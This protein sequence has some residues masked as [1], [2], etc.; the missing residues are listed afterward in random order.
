MVI[1][2]MIYVNAV[3]ALFAGLA[4]FIEQPLADLCCARRL[5]WG[6]AAVLSLAV[7]AVTIATAP[8]GTSL[9]ILDV[10]LLASWAIASIALVASV[11]Y[12]WM[13]FERSVSRF[14]VVQ[15]GEQTVRVSD[16]G[17]A[18]FGL[19]QAAILLPQWLLAG[20]SRTRDI[21]M[22]HEHEHLLARDHLFQLTLLFLALLLH[23]NLALWWIL[24]RTRRAIEMDCDARVIHQR[25]IDPGE[26]AE[27]LLQ[28]NQRGGS[29]PMLAAALT[30][31][32][33]ELEKRIYVICSHKG[34]TSIVRTLLLATLV[35]A[36]LVIATQISSAVP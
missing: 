5:V 21:V 13:T 8:I 29:A 16:V 31:A 25:G 27:V 4:R 26:Y 1:T 30:E 3:T 2:Y 36:T 9:H 11:L 15:L 18:V 32:P 10:V 23:W 28:V 24:Q 34:R 17:P 20:P 35:A 22:T 12:K 14:R 6:L 7:P 33:T 19:R